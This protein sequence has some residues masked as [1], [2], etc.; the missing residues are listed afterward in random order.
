MKLIVGLGNPGEQYKL[1]R[2]NIGFIFI[3]EYLKENRINDIREKYK[4]EFIQTNYKGDKV[5]YQKPLTFMNSSGEA[6]GEAVR[7]FKINPETELFVIYDDMDMEFGKIKI[8]KNGRAAGHNGIKSIISHVGEKF[9][10]IKYGIGK[11]ESKDKTIGYVLGKF[12]PDEKDVLK[13]SRKKIFSLIDD[14]KDEMSI[15]RLMNK[16]NTK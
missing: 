10:R 8:R 7:F 5:F 15:E 11:P 13:E 14:I 16:Y 6:I 3:D 1:T 4:S 9:I 2:H 12:T